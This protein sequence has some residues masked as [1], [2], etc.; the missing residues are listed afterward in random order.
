MSEPSAKI[1]SKGIG[2]VAKEEYITEQ[3]RWDPN[4]QKVAPYHILSEALDMGLSDVK[5]TDPE[6]HARYSSLHAGR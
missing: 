3:I 6:L 5:D 1:Q 2:W 4:R